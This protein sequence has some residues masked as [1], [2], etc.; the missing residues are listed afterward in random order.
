MF[1]N[2]VLLR[3]L[4]Y[5]NASRIVQLKTSDVNRDQ[6]GGISFRIA[7]R[8]GPYLKMAIL[9]AG[10]SLHQCRLTPLQEAPD[11]RIVVD[12]QNDFGTKGL[13]LCSPAISRSISSV[14]V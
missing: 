11:R 5:P 10:S 1:I 6:S 9:A 7:R 2:G 3:A 13:F 8:L 12:M 4:D 14:E